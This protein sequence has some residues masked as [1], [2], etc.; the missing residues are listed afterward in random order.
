ML[1][2]D[3]ASGAAAEVHYRNVLGA[4][5]CPLVIFALRVMKP[6]NQLVALLR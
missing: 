1:M 4:G 5:E 3:P 2:I 6:R